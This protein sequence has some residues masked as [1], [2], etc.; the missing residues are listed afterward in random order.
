MSMYKGNNP[1]ALQSQKW[2][3]GS[4]FELCK[5]KPYKNVSIKE[6]CTRA[7]LSRQTFYMLFKSKEE[8]VELIIDDLFENAISDA[9]IESINM[10][11]LLDLCFGV[12][13]KD[14]PGIKILIENNLMWI[15]RKKMQ[16]RVFKLTP[17]ICKQ[18][19]DEEMSSY[20]AA[21]IS[22]AIIDVIVYIYNNKIQ[23]TSE[24]L[25]ALVFY[26]L[27]GKYLNDFV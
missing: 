1:T 5:A 4:L 8:I 24:E 2:L 10:H 18:E 26:L 25:S 11:T 16:E 17:L 14:T 12:L 22:G 20:T 7:D 27:K 21:F 13:Q 3:K 9:D 23:K 6:L 15:L 19:M